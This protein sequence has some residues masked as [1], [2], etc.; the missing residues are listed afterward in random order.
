MQGA[1]CGPA[2]PLARGTR[3]RGRSGAARSG[4]EAR[5]ARPGVILLAG[6][7]L[8]AIATGS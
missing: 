2:R 6:A 8:V 7:A 5:V 1:E 3:A 4:A